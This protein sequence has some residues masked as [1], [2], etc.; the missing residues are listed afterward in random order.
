MKRGKQENPNGAAC[1]RREAEAHSRRQ[2]CGRS[3]FDIILAEV[4]TM[5]RFERLFRAALLLVILLIPDLSI[6]N[7]GDFDTDNHFP[8]VGRIA[9]VT[10]VFGD[11]RYAGAYCSGSLVAEDVFLTAGHC[12]FFDTPRLAEVPG[13]TAEYWVSFNN[14]VSNNDFFCHLHDIDH[15][16]KDDLGCNPAATNGAIFHKAVISVVHPEYAKIMDTNGTSKIL[17]N[18]I[19][20]GS[21]D[22]S[23]LILEEPIN[24]IIPLDVASSGKF[25]RKQEFFGQP[26][27]GVGYGVDFH[28]SIPATP[29][30]PGGNGPTNF[31]G[32]GTLRRIA[33]I[34]NLQG[35]SAL[36]MTPT[37]N[38][39]RGED[40]ICFGDSGSPLFFGA[41]DGEVDQTVSGVLS[42]GASPWCKGAHD[43]YSRVDSPQAASFISCV[44]TANSVTEVCECGIEDKFGLCD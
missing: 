18:F 30:Q 8:A 34:G 31:E 14:A 3:D 27:T 35:V 32:S 6:A 29:D 19:F 36:W 38:N 11:L 17:E 28:K 40:S 12:Q 9:S 39:A 33:D 44:M 23:L 15:P 20:Q 13:Y 2:P 22:L 37:Q 10:T 43:F 16:N 7:D 42:W 26:L 5:R 24:D 4:I 25:D 1:S 41:F 21:A